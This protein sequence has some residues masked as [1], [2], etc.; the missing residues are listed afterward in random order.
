ERPVLTIRDEIRRLLPMG[1]RPGSTRR[2]FACPIWPP[3]LFA[4]AAT[5]VNTSQCFT[6]PQYVAGW[7]GDYRLDDNYVR[8]VVT[9]GKEWAGSTE[10]PAELAALWEE[11]MAL[12]DCEAG[13]ESRAC[14]WTRVAMRLMAIADEAS[15]WIGFGGRTAFARLLIQQH[16]AYLR[17]R[18]P[19][20]LPN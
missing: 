20:L 6:W 7:D 2:S 18:G 17:K 10:V 14:P 13:R 19:L 16:L 12:G 3:D 4:V 8:E 15:S 1:S 11:L 9:L 5:L